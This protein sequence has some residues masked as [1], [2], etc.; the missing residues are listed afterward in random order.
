MQWN[1]EGFVP[2][3][4]GGL[5]ASKPGVRKA[6]SLRIVVYEEDVFDFVR[7]VIDIY[8]DFRAEKKA[9]ARFK[10][11]F[12]TAGCEWLRREIEIRMGVKFDMADDFNCNPPSEHTEGLQD[13]GKNYY[14]LPVFA[15]I[16][17]SEKLRFVAEVAEEFD[18]GIRL[19]PWQNVVFTD[20]DDLKAL[21]E[22]L[23]ENFDLSAPRMHIACASNFCG[24]TLVHAKDVLRLIPASDRFV[25]VSGCSNA[26][27][28]HPLAEIG[29][30]GKVK[31]GNQLYDVFI[32][33]WKEAENL[34]VEEAVELVKKHL[35]D[36]YG[37]KAD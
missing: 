12:E 21:K 26:C 35:G 7:T 3:V 25:G 29:L 33:G 11:F 28:C 16:L 19:T 36:G 20:I 13:D 9:E 22:R 5:G 14:A 30:C 6:K 10:N 23:S 15:G 24:K 17:D 34:S 2:L 8:R 37:A 27:A 31:A 32:H 1:G 18:G 4:G